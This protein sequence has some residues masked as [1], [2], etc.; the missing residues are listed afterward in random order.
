MLKRSRAKKI[1]LDHIHTFWFPGS[2]SG[3]Q[4]S[5]YP[6][7]PRFQSSKSADCKSTGFPQGQPQAAHGINIEN[8]NACP[9]GT[10]HLRCSGTSWPTYR[11]SWLRKPLDLIF[12]S[13]RSGIRPRD[14]SDDFTPASLKQVTMTLSQ[15]ESRIPE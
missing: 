8:D 9:D 5:R 14:I 10:G 6:R 4:I 15:A 12:G 13:V 11:D 3:S 1:N 7:A 2:R